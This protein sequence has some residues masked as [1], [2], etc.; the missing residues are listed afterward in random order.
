M[1]HIAIPPRRLALFFMLASGALSGCSELER[2]EC[3]VQDVP[4][5]ALSPALVC[6]WSED[7]GI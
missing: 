7:H 3:R 6:R 5:L 1:K 4:E 2:L